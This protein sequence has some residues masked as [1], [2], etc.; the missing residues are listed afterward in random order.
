MVSGATAVS[1]VLCLP[2]EGRRN[3]ARVI[4]SFILAS[5]LVGLWLDVE[6]TGFLCFHAAQEPVRVQSTPVTESNQLCRPPRESPS[7][8]VAPSP[9]GNRTCSVTLV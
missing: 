5:L 3:P 1:K 6:G 7:R 2:P 4:Y 9:D 8:A